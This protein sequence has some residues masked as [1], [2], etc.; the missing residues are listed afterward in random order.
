[1]QSLRKRK[2]AKILCVLG[3]TS[4][5]MMPAAYAAIPVIDV[6]NTLQQAKTY[7]E[8]IKV[9]TNT[10]KTLEVVIL[11]HL[12][13]SKEDKEAFHKKFDEGIK[14]VTAILNG[15]T[16]GIFNTERH[17]LDERDGK[18]NLQEITKMYDEQ[19]PQVWADSIV[20]SPNGNNPGSLKATIE[21][22][23][24]ARNRS[25]GSLMENNKSTLKQYA[26]LM[27]E[28][29]AAMKDLQ[30]LQDASSNAKGIMQ[31]QQIA[32]DIYATNARIDNIRTAIL[33]IKG[34]NDV[35]QNQ[36]EAQSRQNDIQMQQAM[37]QASANYAKSLKDRGVSFRMKSKPYNPWDGF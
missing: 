35:M 1:M 18:I 19:F 31:A 10:A 16:T 26:E 14:K 22:W 8:T 15:D 27:G 20:A 2:F 9:V 13:L 12:G 17:P 32:N 37:N 6:D 25:I 30:D 24:A 28:L 11:D 29:H 5:L 34:Q 7:A 23:K 33:A 21:L 36:A 3:T 4:I